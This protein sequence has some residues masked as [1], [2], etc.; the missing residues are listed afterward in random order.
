MKKLLAVL[1]IA[2]LVVTALGA[3]KI[4]VLAW[5][6]AH[7]QAWVQN[8]KA[9]EKATG[10]K[11]D[12]ELIPSG[13]MLQK[14]ALNI[15]ENKANY[16]LVAIDEGNV[17]KFGNLLIP[18]SQWP[19]GKVFKKISTSEIPQAIFAAALWNGKIQG[20]PINGNVY[21]WMTRKDLIENP[22]YKK[23]FME[24]FGYEL[25]VPETLDQLANMA[26]FFA[27]KGIYGF[28]PFT[29][30]TEGSTCEAIM[31]FEA[32]GTHFM[33]QVN[34][35]YVITLDKE[36][37]IEA[38]LFYKRLMQYA[39]P[40]ANDMGHSERIAAF[41]D[42]KVFS[43]F[44]WPGIIP[45]HE[46]EDE[47]LVAGKIIYTAP[48]AG[49]AR[50]AAVRGCWILGIPKASKNV[51]AAA[52]FAYWLNSHDAGKKLAEDGMTPVRTDLLT[53][54][55]LLAKSPWYQG[56]AESGLFAVSRPNRVT[57]YP[58]ISEKIKVNWLAAVTGAVDPET[59]VDNMISQVQE[60]LDKYE[61]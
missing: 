8:L 57:Y 28:A 56:M 6:D 7:T 60:L 15:T 61:K 19:E 3:T 23:E 45:T 38:I 34:G 2:L 32:F 29:K 53:D 30:N 33:E 11:V 37:A 25:K 47:S 39:P 49:P 16:D 41:S 9:F 55:E 18:Y 27:S 54:P 26:E 5:D 35:K 1:F 59:A 17:A 31:F 52:E 46:N 36:K 12:L 10:I 4:R 50:R 13:S 24:K 51:E 22:Q 42:G 44:Q 48:P 40:G 43:M 20:I 58:E 14:T 21:V